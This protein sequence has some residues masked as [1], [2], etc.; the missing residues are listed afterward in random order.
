MVLS[1]QMV[2]ATRGTLFYTNY[3]HLSVLP[4]VMLCYGR[5]DN[6]KVNIIMGK[7]LISYLHSSLA[8]SLHPTRENMFL[9]FFTG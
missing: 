9:C 5:I 8:S 2:R 6:S 7:L 3:Q 1:I 4:Q